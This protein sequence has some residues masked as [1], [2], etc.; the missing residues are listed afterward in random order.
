MAI[1]PEKVRQRHA[2]YNRSEKGKA[3]YKRYEDK[4][5]DRALR[6]SPILVARAYDPLKR[7]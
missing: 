5:P 6:W 1:D 2:R 7:G 4:H 3:R